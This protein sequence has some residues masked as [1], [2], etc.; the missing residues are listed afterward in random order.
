MERARDSTD[1]TSD[2][3]VGLLLLGRADQEA[4]AGH[5]FL[6][7]LGHRSGRGLVNGGE[8]EKERQ[9]CFPRLVVESVKQNPARGGYAAAAMDFSGSA[10]LGRD[11]AVQTDLDGLRPGKLKA[12]GF[13]R[14]DTYCSTGGPKYLLLLC[15]QVFVF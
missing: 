6:L 15:S 13:F 5:G 8:R 4:P 3:G 10:K 2:D 12:R 11:P 1:A 14:I 7:A 9:S